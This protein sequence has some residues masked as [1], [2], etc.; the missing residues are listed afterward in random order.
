MADERSEL[1]VALLP[2]TEAL[3]RLGVRWC[4]VGSVASGAHGE[5]RAT[6][7]VDLVADLAPAH[8]APLVA[9]L[10]E[11]YYVDEESV[12]EAI[13]R[14]SSFNLVHLGTMLKVDVFAMKRR[15]YDRASMDRRVS[16]GIDPDPSSPRLQLA[17]P[18]DTVLAKL[19]WYR[20]GGEVSERQWKDVLGVLR[21]QGGAIDRAYMARWA[22]ELGVADLLE[23]ALDA[24]HGV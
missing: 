12:T 18:E 2:V 24:A 1:L 20:A 3:D 8:A 9:A 14:R 13:D 15:P 10:A 4:V 5:Y 22:P 19:A 7:D 17:S 23:R 16:H 6:H 21:V 11:S